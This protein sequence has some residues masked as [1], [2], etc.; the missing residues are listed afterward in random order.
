MVD[1]WEAVARR[2]EMPM[3]WEYIYGLDTED[4]IYGYETEDYIYG[5]SGDDYLYAYGGDDYIYTGYGNDWAA[6]G[7]GSDILYGEFGND[8][9]YGEYGEDDLYGGV[10]NDNLYGGFGADEL[11]GGSGRDRLN[12]GSEND[13]LVGGGGRDYLA[14]G[15]GSDT[16]VFT[17]GSS[18]LGSTSADVITDWNGAFDFIDMPVRGTYDNYE[19]AGTTATSISTAVAQ[20]NSWFPDPSVQH[21][22][23]HNPYVD[24][25]FLI[26]DLNG[27]G[28]FDTGI[29]L[30]KAGYASDFSYFDIV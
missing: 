3:A 23:L 22:F 12:G 16:F 8:I 25:G 6:G 2:E 24:K 26:S 7:Y 10:G 29:V 21:V 28:A 30:N 27:D 17:K 5:Y 19:E 4:Y 20:A 1:G 11:F 9:L 15:S 18:G 14:G 13:W